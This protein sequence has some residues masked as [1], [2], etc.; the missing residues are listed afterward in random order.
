MNQ[1]TVVATKIQLTFSAEQGIG[2]FRWTIGWRARFAAKRWSLR[3]LPRSVRARFWNVH[4][5]F[6]RGTRRTP[7]R[8]ATAS[9]SAGDECEQRGKHSGLRGSVGASGGRLSA[10]GA[11]GRSFPF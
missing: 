10:G 2:Q 4:Y 5:R 8:G 11:G 7:S 3:R 9:R 6:R 1:G